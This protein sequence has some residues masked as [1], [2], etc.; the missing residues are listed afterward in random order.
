MAKPHGN[1]RSGLIEFF[2]TADS[3]GK[4][5]SATVLAADYAS[6]A[7]GMAVMTRGDGG[8]DEAGAFAAAA[9]L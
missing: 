6:A 2:E 7:A 1:S 5:C 9:A 3:K 8:H 4:M